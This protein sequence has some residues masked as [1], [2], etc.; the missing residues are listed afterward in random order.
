MTRHA[1][2]PQIDRSTTDLQEAELAWGV[3]HRLGS[4]FNNDEEAREAWILNRD[5]I[6][7]LFAFGG[8]RPM[9]WWRHESPLPWPG[10][11]RERST[12][13]EAGLLGAAE[14]RALE[15]D[16]REEFFKSLAPGFTFREREGHYLHGHEAHIA[17]LVFHDCP[18]A[19]AERFSAELPTAA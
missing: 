14:R 4:T 2:K 5:R 17:A 9:G 15:A 19:L 3:S 13:W 6:M 7:N 8:R 18:A 11:S 10:F 16:W 1:N 12:L